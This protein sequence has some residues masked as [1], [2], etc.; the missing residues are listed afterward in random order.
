MSYLFC[1]TEKLREK[2]FI[3]KKL[4][5][6]PFFQNY[7]N[8][9]VPPNSRNLT[10]EPSNG[11]QTQLR[12]RATA[13]IWTYPSKKEMKFHAKNV[14]GTSKIRCNQ[15]D[16]PM[17]PGRLKYHIQEV[18]EKVKD[19]RCNLCG[20]T[21]G[22][23]STLKKHLLNFHREGGN[24]SECSIC[25]KTCTSEDG[26]KA[27]MKFAH[28]REKPHECLTCDAEFKTPTALVVHNRVH[29][30]E[31]PYKCNICGH[32]FSQSHSLKEHTDKIHAR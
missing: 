2:G 27:H 11:H 6:I 3:F 15:C 4:R 13:R 29:T 21:F 5:M 7:R 32:T 26:I 18:H 1:I 16:T 23:W 19:H 24:S 17:H 9:E 20:K 31:K 10:S 14:H 30:G 28:S 8:K 12:S 22:Q 25:S